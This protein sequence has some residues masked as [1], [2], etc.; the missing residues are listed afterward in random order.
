MDHEYPPI[1]GVPLFGTNQTIASG[2]SILFVL[3]L[4]KHSKNLAYGEHSDAVKK[5]RVAAI[6]SL[7]GKKMGNSLM[8]I[9]GNLLLGTG[10]L[11]LSADF[12]ARCSNGTWFLFRLF[13]NAFFFL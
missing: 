10:A 1:T 9:I 8:Q 6:Q 7:S 5:N 12:L 2:L 3:I 13:R 4:V 11:R